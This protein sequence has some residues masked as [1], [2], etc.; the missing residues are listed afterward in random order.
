[1]KRCGV[2]MRKRSKY[3]PRPIIAN[4]MAY[5]MSGMLPVMHMKE[6]MT[7][8]QLKNH[9]AI[10][11][12]RKG[13]ATKSDIDLLINALNITEALIKHKIG[14]EYA[15]E[16]KEAQN[17]L[18]ECAKR[19]AEANRFVAKGTELKAINLAMEIHDAQ[20]DVITVKELEK[21]TDLVTE[22]IRNKRARPIVEHHD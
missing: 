8:L 15:N 17:A 7:S 14:A 5:V 20:L 16:L 1:M 2:E 19:G 6:H 11:S 9:L 18:Y 4:T 22:T 10:E 13:E 3:R 12:F 21:A